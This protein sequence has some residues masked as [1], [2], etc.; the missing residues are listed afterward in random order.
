MPTCKSCPAPILWCVWESTGRAHPVDFAPVPDGDIVVTDD[1]KSQPTV[2]KATADDPPGPRYK[3]HFATCPKAH[4][5][6]G[7]R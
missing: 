7:K 4:M 3:S 1:G 6:R 5:F 2:R